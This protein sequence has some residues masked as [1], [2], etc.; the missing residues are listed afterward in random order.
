M[1]YYDP[2]VLS[3]YFQPI[4]VFE[5]DGGFVAYVP[6]VTA[7]YYGTETPAPAGN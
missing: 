3:Q 5:G 6:A 2:D 7:E 1:A 4:V